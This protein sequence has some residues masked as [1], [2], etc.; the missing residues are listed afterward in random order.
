M[1]EN[2][3]FAAVSGKDAAIKQSNP[4]LMI[5]DR[6]VYKLVVFPEDEAGKT[7]RQLAAEISNK[8]PADMNIHSK[9]YV[10]IA[11]FEGTELMEP[12]LIRWIQRVCN[13]HNRF[14]VWFNNFGTSPSECL[15]LRIMDAEPFLKLISGLRAID[16]YIHSNNNGKIK[17]FTRPVCSLASGPAG[18]SWF[19]FIREQLKQEFHASFQSCS[20]VLLKSVGDE[21]ENEAELV[22]VFPLFP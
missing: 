8:A 20:L 9:P 12:T 18:E 7:V 6:L 2:G 10:P 17:W 3:L 16:D 19:E 13:S 14:T 15:H 1:Q 4:G 21:Q 22:N 11:A 5:T